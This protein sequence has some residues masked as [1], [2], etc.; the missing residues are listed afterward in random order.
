VVLGFLIILQQ[1]PANPIAGMLPILLMFGILYFVLIL[2]MQR[3]K[4]A[5][6]TMLGALK[7]GD[8]VATT[9]GIV[10][11]IVSLNGDIVVIRVKPDNVK[12]QI[13]RSAVATVINA[14]SK[15]S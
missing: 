6:Q 9:G 13:A 12:L 2:P 14:E 10:G 11:S 3:Q 5:T 15:Q 4:K 7:T 8:E 1:S